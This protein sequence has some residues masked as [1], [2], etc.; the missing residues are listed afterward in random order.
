M[1]GEREGARQANPAL[2][3]PSQFRLLRRVGADG[4]LVTWEPPPDPAV[5][6]YLVS[7]QCRPPRRASLGGHCSNTAS[8]FTED[9]PM[10]L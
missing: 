9:R 7:T 10:Q 2:L 5:T 8:D 4:L 3:P 1:A 6:G